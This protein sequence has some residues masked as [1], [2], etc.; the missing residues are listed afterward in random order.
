[1]KKAVQTEL[2][3]FVAKRGSEWFFSEPLLGYY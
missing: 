1:M 2:P 3:Q